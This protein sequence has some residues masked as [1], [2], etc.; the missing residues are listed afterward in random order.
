M[1][2]HIELVHVV[3]GFG[4]VRGRVVHVHRHSHRRER[5]AVQSG[6]ITLLTGDHWVASG[7]LVRV[8]CT[9]KISIKHWSI[10]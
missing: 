8:G 10:T 7:R 1:R 6:P 4:V 3:H 9:V 2:W 5:L